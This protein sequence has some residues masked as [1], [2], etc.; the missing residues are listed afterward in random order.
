VIIPTNIKTTIVALHSARHKLPDLSCHTY[1][2]RKQHQ[3]NKADAIAISNDIGANAALE[4]LQ[5]AKA[6]KEMFR[7]LP[8]AKVASPS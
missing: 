8:H 4:R 3:A 7:R 2:V 1:T 5:L 6:T